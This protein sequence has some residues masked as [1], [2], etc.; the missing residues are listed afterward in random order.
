MTL[1][2]VRA[3]VKA[4][5]DRPGK[6]PPLSCRR[7][8]RKKPP[9]P[10]QLSEAMQ[11]RLCTM[12]AA[13]WSVAGLRC[14]RVRFKYYGRRYYS[15]LCLVGLQV[16]DAETGRRVCGGMSDRI[17]QPGVTFVRRGEWQRLMEAKFARRAA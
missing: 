8:R 15:T 3:L 16:Y 1:S 5:M 6:L 13:H 17:G 4:R 12:A 7:S 14:R 11:V 2:K 9:A 10:R